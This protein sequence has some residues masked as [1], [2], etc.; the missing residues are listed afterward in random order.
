MLDWWYNFLPQILQ[1]SWIGSVKLTGAQL[2]EY[3]SLYK[4]KNN[5]LNVDF[6]DAYLP[7]QPNLLCALTIFGL[8]SAVLFIVFLISCVA[9]R[10]GACGASYFSDEKPAKSSYRFMAIYFSLGIC[11]LILFVTTL[12]LALCLLDF[13]SKNIGSPSAVLETTD[14]LTKRGLQTHSEL[15]RHVLVGLNKV[16]IQDD[17]SHHHHQQPLSSVSENHLLHKYNDIRE[18]GYEF[19]PLD[20]DSENFL[21]YFGFLI[22]LMFYT[23]TLIIAGLAALIGIREQLLIYHPMDRTTHSD[24]AGRTLVTIAFL[25]FA[26]SPLVNFFSSVLLLHT[27]AHTSICP[28]EQTLSQNSNIEDYINENYN[29][30]EAVSLVDFLGDLSTERV[31]INIANCGEYIRPMQGIWS[32][33]L[34]LSWMSIPAIFF[35]IQLSKYFLKKNGGRKPTSMDFT[36]WN[37]PANLDAYSSVPDS[38]SSP[39]TFGTFV[40]Q[41]Y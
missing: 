7:S 24:R 35:L 14:E 34:V 37:H 39:Y 27:H 33:L 6:L 18:L 20:R 30:F 11:W 19:K 22:L 40:Y 4:H 15:E 36:N 1:D 28:Y 2:D 23:I 16:T 41:K 25:M 5:L 17:G 26:V 3:F 8:V 12:V 38:K 9:K 13:G 10:L 21:K 32:C 29:F 31:D